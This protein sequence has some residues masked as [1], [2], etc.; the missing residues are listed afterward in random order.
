MVLMNFFKIKFINFL[1]SIHIN[2]YTIFTYTI[3]F[4]LFFKW[5]LQ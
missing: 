1:N 5:I 3:F 4:L 2:I